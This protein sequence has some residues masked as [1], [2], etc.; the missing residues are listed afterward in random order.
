MNMRKIIGT[1]ACSLMALSILVQ[2]ALAQAP[3][4]GPDWVVVKERKVRSFVPNPDKPGSGTW[5]LIDVKNRTYFVEDGNV[6]RK[7]ANSRKESN[8]IS[9]GRSDRVYGPEDI[10]TRK[11]GETLQ[12]DVPNSNKTAPEGDYLVTSKLTRYALWE[13]V[14]GTKPWTVY[15]RYATRTRDVNYYV[16]EWVDPLTGENLSE[17][18]PTPE[19]TE[20]VVG[21]AYNKEVASS[22]QERI[23]RRDSL[24]T[25][26]RKVVL[27]RLY[28]PQATLADE[29][30]L[31][32]SKMGTFLSNKGAGNSQV[33]LSG[34][35][36]RAA[37]GANEAVASQAR[38]TSSGGTIGGDKIETRYS[39][40]DRIGGTWKKKGGS[41]SEV[42]FERAG[43]S[44]NVKVEVKFVLG[45]GID[46]EHSFTAPFSKSLAGSPKDGRGYSLTFNDAGTELTVKIGLLTETFVKSSGRDDDD[47]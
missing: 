36:L 42:K 41:S 4:L 30:R 9:V 24:G 25:E 13:D 11:K 29:S 23:A 18:L 14:A 47:D 32:G 34:S 20:W 15:N 35:K 39:L 1:A 19:Y 45:K 44:D 3:N 33:A 7:V 46:I 22:G 21:A 26:D 38:T 37:M 6:S 8:E 43:K 17:Y 5:Q 12:G 27:G 16:I 28:S 10:K 40:I 2:P 31:S